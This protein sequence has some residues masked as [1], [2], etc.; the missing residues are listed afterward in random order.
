MTQFIQSDQLLLEDLKSFAAGDTLALVIKNY[1]SQIEV[2]DADQLNSHEDLEEYSYVTTKNGR[3]HRIPFGV[4][5][6]GTPFSSSFG[7]TAD[8]EARQNYYRHALPGMKK[9]R[10]IFSPRISPID[11]LRI[12]FDEI[13]P[14][15][16][17]VGRIEGQ[18]MFTGIV[19]ITEPQTDILEKR[20]HV[21]AMTPDIPF[22]RQFA[23]NIYLEVPDEGG[24]LVIYPER[25]FLS[26]EEVHDITVNENLWSHNLGNPLKIKPERGDLILIHTQIPHA[27]QSFAKGRRI[28]VQTF[29]ACDQTNKINFWC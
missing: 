24:E 17:G 7:K 2:S 16:A 5:R 26:Q 9:L 14:D 3:T 15:G 6:L 21:D 28:S 1:Y 23:A 20:P 25:G 27:V 11:Q 18:T 8:S 10:K 22:Q 19:R 12:D 29:F 4:K 13:W